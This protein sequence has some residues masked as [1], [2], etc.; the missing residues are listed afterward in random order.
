MR[1]L[2][3][4]PDAQAL[5]KQGRISVGHAKVLLSSNPMKSKDF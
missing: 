2:D 5:L 4:E 1:L 3:L